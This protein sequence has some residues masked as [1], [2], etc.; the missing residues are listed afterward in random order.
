MHSRWMAL[1]Y[2]IV[3]VLSSYALT[4]C[5][6]GPNFHSPHAPPV[7]SYNEFPLPAKT[8]SVRTPGNSGKAQ[9]YVTNKD[10]QAEWW[11]LFRSPALD[12]LIHTGLTNSPNLAAAQAALRQAQE[13]LNAQI[14]TSLYPAFNAQLAGQRQRATG[15]SSSTGPT[16]GSSG[17]SNVFNLFNAAVNVSYTLDIFGGARREIESLQAQV[18]YQQF[19]L[20]A[21]YLTL[22]SNIATTAITIASLEGQI[23]ATRQLIKEQE[24]QLTII[25]N[26]FRLGAIAESNVLTQQTLLDQ[27][28]AT[29]PPL[30]KSL[31]QSKHALSV[32]IGEFPNQELPKF[33][34]DK[35]VLP[36]EL[37]ISLPS[38]LVRQR[39]DVRASEALLH[40]ASAQIGVATAN[41][42]PQFTLTGSY[43]WTAT[44]PSA[45]FKS[46]SKEW[47][48]ASQLTQPLFQG[49]ALLA[50]RRAAI[51]AYDQAAAQYRQ[52]V[53][54]A[55]QNVA[56]SLR[57][58]ETD[59]RTLRAQ[60][61]AEM[62][63]YKSLKLSQDQYRLG[64]VSYLNLLTAQQQYQQTVIARIQAQA[65]RYS[66]T[67]ALFQSLGGGWWNRP[68][69]ACHDTVN[70]TQASL[71]CP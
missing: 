1:R 55:F 18:D 8:A 17:G 22:T 23:K 64:G 54:Q 45:L 42:F 29:L 2:S 71:I 61:Q 49:G 33:D 56:D 13:L 58:L 24:N 25:N 3:V 11:T 41:L 59:A 14:G 44:V 4:G 16:G 6:V 69:A 48:I 35:L 46:A 70:P 67:V 20:I 53:L 66:D 60:R 10:I 65:A 34:L 40:A 62:A 31:S 32:L 39:P 63:A 26:Q 38:A 28:R 68:I 43:G 51:A 57:A 5:M 37:P 47:S 9:H 52:T 50:Q 21:A 12:A 15:L 7:H 27:T 36:V 30:E 19:Q